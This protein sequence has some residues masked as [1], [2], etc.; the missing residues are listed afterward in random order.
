M[1][2]PGFTAEGSFYKTS[3]CHQVLRNGAS[4]ADTQAVIPQFIGR[5]VIC[6]ALV[7]IVMESCVL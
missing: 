3:E 7:T 5:G 1:R 6:G 2:M 4:R